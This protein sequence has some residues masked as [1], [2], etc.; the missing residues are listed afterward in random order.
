MPLLGMVRI[1]V[2]A[3]SDAQ[4]RA[5]AAPA[6]VRWIETFTFLS[7]TRNL[8]VPADLPTSFE[9]GLDD[10]FCLVGSPSTVLEALQ[11]QVAE[12][13]VTYVMCQIAFGDLPLAASLQT[14]SFMRS[15][16]MPALRRPPG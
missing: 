16:V 15:T 13:G 9:Q 2:I 14:I 12:A 5:L 10:G 6:Y 8:P 4:A 11:R 1:V 3:G 7:R